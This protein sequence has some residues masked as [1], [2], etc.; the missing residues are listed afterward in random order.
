MLFVF[1]RRFF[2]SQVCL[3]P[4]VHI[5]FVELDALQNRVAEF[6]CPGIAVGFYYQSLQS[7]QRSAA[8]S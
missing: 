4:A 3:D 2:L 8:I 7:Q 5:L 1:P 6:V